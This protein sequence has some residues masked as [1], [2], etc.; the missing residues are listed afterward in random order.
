MSSYS[1]YVL[2]SIQLVF[3]N[4]DLTNSM[5]RQ[6]IYVNIIYHTKEKH[7]LLKCISWH[8][9]RRFSFPGR[10]KNQLG[11]YHYLGQLTMAL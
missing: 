9:S 10:L 5:T 1:V 11:V 8:L 6:Y 3:S 2:E 4:S 7:T